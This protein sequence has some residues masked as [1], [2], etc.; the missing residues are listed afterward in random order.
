MPRNPTTV[1][2]LCLLLAPYALGCRPQFQQGPR[3]VRFEA[4]A[5]TR[6]LGV[7][8]HCGLSDLS[9]VQ[10]SWDVTASDIRRAQPHVM[11]GLA[12]ALDSTSLRGREA[13]YILQYFGIVLQGRRVILIN[14]FHHLVTR[15][16]SSR[17]WKTEPVSSCDVGPAAFQADFDVVT[18]HLSD[19]RFDPGWPGPR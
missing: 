11:R 15:T 10:G 6:Y 19:I 14:G 4:A 7:L 2:L 17:R 18:G 9:A 12:V 3:A 16:E 8:E 13:E 5:T 1:S